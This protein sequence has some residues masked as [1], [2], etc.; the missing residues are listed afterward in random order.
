MTMR[1]IHQPQTKLTEARTIELEDCILY[2]FLLKTDKKDAVLEIELDG[3][4]IQHT[5]EELNELGLDRR[6]NWLYLA[7]YNETEGIFVCCWSPTPALKLEKL[8]LALLPVTKPVTATW[9]LLYQPQEKQPEPEKQETE[10]RRGIL[11]LG[12]LR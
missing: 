10:E 5:P 8:K 4:K 3:S 11:G 12:L 7:K 6:S 1:V 2:F 9:L